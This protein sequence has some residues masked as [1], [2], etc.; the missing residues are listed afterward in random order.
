M[1][2]GSDGFGSRTLAEVRALA[3]GVTQIAETEALPT[4]EIDPR[5]V[6]VVHVCVAGNAKFATR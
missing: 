5:I 1:S 4:R 6:S 3:P 2:F